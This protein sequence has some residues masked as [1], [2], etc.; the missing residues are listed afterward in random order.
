MEHGGLVVAEAILRPF[1]AKIMVRI[2]INIYLHSEGQ[3][4][5]FLLLDS[6]HERH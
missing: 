1:M 2:G 4:R 6:T 3:P 5:T